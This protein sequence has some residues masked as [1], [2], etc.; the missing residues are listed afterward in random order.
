MTNLCHYKD[1]FGKPG[2]GI[3]AYRILDLSVIDIIM[4]LL[5]AFFLSQLF[6]FPNAWIWI[7]VAL[8]S[9]GVMMHRIFCVRTTVDK[10]LFD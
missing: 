7:T 3:H 2:E 1:M 6:P 5:G 10:I 9:L 4:T 8:F